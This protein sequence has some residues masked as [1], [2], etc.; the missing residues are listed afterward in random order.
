MRFLLDECLGLD[1]RKLKT[2]TLASIDGQVQVLLGLIDVHIF[3][4]I[5][6]LWENSVLNSN[7]HKLGK[8]YTSLEAMEQIVVFRIDGNELL[9]VLVSVEEL[10]DQLGKANPFFD[11]KRVSESTFSDT[12]RYLA[13][14][15]ENSIINYPALMV[16][17][18]ANCS[19]FCNL[20]CLNI[21]TPFCQKHLRPYLEELRPRQCV[22]LV[23]IVLRHHLGHLFLSDVSLAEILEDL[24]ELSHVHGSILVHVVALERVLE[25][26][27]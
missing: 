9:A 4:S 23:L 12:L 25:L 26:Y 20:S 7:V 5:D 13:T 15:F 2:N 19:E 22:V 16:M 24:L 17:T 14:I 27:H 1:S 18:F 3:L 6:C 8:Y 10:I 11:Q 21:Y